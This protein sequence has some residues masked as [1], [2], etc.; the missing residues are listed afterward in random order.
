[1]GRPRVPS[2]VQGRRSGRV[3]R[4]GGARGRC[5]WGCRRGRRAGPVHLGLQAR[6]ARGAGAPGR[7]RAGPAFA[8]GPAH[9]PSPA[10]LLAPRSRLLCVVRPRRPAQVGSWGLVAQGLGVPGSRCWVAGR[11]EGGRGVAWGSAPRVRCGPVL[12]RGP[13]GFPSPGRVAAAALW[14]WRCPQGSGPAL[15]TQTPSVT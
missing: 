8:R 15:A 11:A 5:T 14:P 13:L 1:V 2:G 4:A 10:T 12:A 3:R 9:R 6:E 7:A